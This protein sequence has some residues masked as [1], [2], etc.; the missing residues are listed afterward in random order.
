MAAPV[1]EDGVPVALPEAAFCWV[2]NRVFTLLGATGVFQ[3][4]GGLLLVAAA[5]F[6]GAR[7]IRTA[8]SD[9][10]MSGGT[11]PPRVFF[12]C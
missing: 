3:T 6:S 8:F 2:F 9:I 7:V 1:V 5:A 11:R 4:D 10:L 12:L